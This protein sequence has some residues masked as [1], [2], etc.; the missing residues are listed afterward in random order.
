MEE[1]P[2]DGTIIEVRNDSGIA[3]SF[4]LWKWSTDRSWKSPDGSTVVIERDPTWIG[5]RD[6]KISFAESAKFTWRPW[7]GDPDK[8]IDP[9]GGLQ[10]SP[11]YWRGAHAA[12]LGQWPDYF[13]ST[14]AE[15]TGGEQGMVVKKRGWF[16]S[17]IGLGR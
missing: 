13:E 14:M 15:K 9:T 7:E 2:R 8:Y 3:P 1:A 12:K 17:W 16:W 6:H 4:G 10:N 11:A 5:V